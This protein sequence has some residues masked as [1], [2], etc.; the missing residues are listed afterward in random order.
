MTDNSDDTIIVLLIED[1]EA[2][3]GLIKAH[4]AGRSDP[5]FTLHHETTLHHG[6]KR[7]Q[8]TVVDIIVLD[9]SLPDS[10]GFETFQ[11]VKEAVH[12]VPIVILSGTKDDQVALEAVRQGAQDFFSKDEA[13]SESLGRSLQYAIERFHRQR[14][15]REIDAAAFIQQRLYPRPLPPLPG[16]DVA[17]RCT[18]ANQV[19]GDYF[20]YFLADGNSLILVI[21]DVSGHGF[22]PSLVMAETRA[23]LRTM[24]TTTDDIGTMIRRVNELLVHDDLGPFV[25]LFLAR[26]DVTTRFCHYASAGQPAELIRADHSAETLEG[27]APPL[28]ILAG[29]PL[30]VHETQLRENDTLLL[31]TDGISERSPGPPELFGVSR[32][33]ELIADSAELTAAQTLERLFD[34]ANAFANARPAAD[35]MTAIVLK[36]VSAY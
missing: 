36:V 24:A 34:E 29:S 30:A 8:E 9:L 10:G 15:E 18:P 32:M 3:A 21:G 7:L 11:S 1:S 33:R 16:F 20:D 27:S 12:G 6:L 13:I 19:G 22:G 28:G 4:L 17:G 35:D 2:D 5:S 26:I 31:Y 14:V 23:A 25:S